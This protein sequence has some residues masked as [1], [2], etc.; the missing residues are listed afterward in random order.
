MKKH[1][2]GARP[3][4]N[5]ARCCVLFA[6]LLVEAVSNLGEEIDFAR[7]SFFFGLRR[8]GLLYS[9]TRKKITSASSRKPTTI[10]IHEPYRWLLFCRSQDRDRRRDRCQVIE[11]WLAEDT[12]HDRHD[13]VVDQAL[14][15]WRKSQGQNQADGGFE[16]AALVYKVFEFL[17]H[18]FA[19]QKAVYVG[20]MS[21]AR[22]DDGSGESTF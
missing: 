22:L 10:V 20:F 2:S 4:P 1:S 13:D 15:H 12:S 19:S 6:V 9:F 5:A 7:A 17:N 21:P 8:V 16:Y 11:A 14:H 18:C 3:K